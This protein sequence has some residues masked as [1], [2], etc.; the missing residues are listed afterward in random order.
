M[1]AMV[2]FWNSCGKKVFSR[3]SRRK[4]LQ[5]QQI[6]NIK[7]RSLSKLVSCDKR[8]GNAKS[9]SESFVKSLAKFFP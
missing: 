8:Q 3:V 2:K 7:C 9:K 4:V 1:E 5:L 6:S